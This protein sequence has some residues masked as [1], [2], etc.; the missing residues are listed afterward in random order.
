MRK[1]LRLAFVSALI[2]ATLITAF[3][4][5]WLWNVF[6]SARSTF[7]SDASIALFMSINKYVSD[8]TSIP[9]GFTEKDIVYVHIDSLTYDDNGNIIKPDKRTYD[10]H[11]LLGGK[12]FRANTNFQRDLPVIREIFKEELKKSDIRLDFI[13]TRIELDE[14]IK[15]LGPSTI[16]APEEHRAYSPLI[17]ATFSGKNIHVFKKILPSV[18]FSGILIILTGCCL[19]YM[20]YNLRRQLRLDA[21]KNNF[22]SNIT[23]ELRT[24]VSI[25]RSTHEALDEFGHI[26][27]KEK[28]LRYLR[29]NRSVLDQLDANIDRMLTIASMEN[30]AGPAVEKANLYKL[31]EQVLFR[32]SGNPEV[33]M[34]LKYRLEQTTLPIPV[35]T[36]ET[37]LINLADNAIKYSHKPVDIS[38]SAIPAG[39]GW[40]LQVQDNGIG[41][42]KQYIPYLFDRFYRV[43]T[44]NLHDVKG[45]GLGLNYVKQLADQ[46]KAT[47]RVSSKP[48]QGTLFSIEFPFYENH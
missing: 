23:H 26:D 6:V 13:L 3:Q 34:T 10:S 16:T 11:M 35:S 2:T 22:I 30:K 21:M 29:A 39:K 8:R 9:K 18:I 17:V 19:Y 31:L 1:K 28:A 7:T 5:Y 20:F 25:L 12:L 27:D 4:L 40:R 41:I 36:I 37:I 45:F 48:G 44:G 46:A 38:V 14:T 15:Y 43:P 32:F 42:E 24:P 47:I 33:N